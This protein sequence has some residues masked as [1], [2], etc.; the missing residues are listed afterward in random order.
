[1]L[2]KKCMLFSSEIVVHSGNIHGSF[3]ECPISLTGTAKV[4]FS[5]P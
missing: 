3:K 2:Q 4:V 5:F 1:M